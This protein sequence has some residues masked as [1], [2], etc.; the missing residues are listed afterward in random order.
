M[1]VFG[2]FTMNKQVSSYKKIV[3]IRLTK[4]YSAVGKLVIPCN[5]S[6]K[7]LSIETHLKS[8]SYEVLERLSSYSKQPQNDV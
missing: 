6:L 4:D 3:V 2:N 8:S 7:L 5:K 1:K